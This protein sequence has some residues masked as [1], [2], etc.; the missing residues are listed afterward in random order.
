MIEQHRLRPHHVAMVM[1]GKIRPQGLPV[2]GLVEAGPVVPM[3]PPSTLAQI[4]K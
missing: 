1:T 4:T 2:A 3:Q